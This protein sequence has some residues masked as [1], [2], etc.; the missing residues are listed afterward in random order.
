MRKGQV[1]FTVILGIIIIAVIAIFYAFSSGLIGPSVI[2]PAV[3]KQMGVVK[4]TV[5]NFIRAAVADIMMN[6][7]MYG[8]YLNDNS[9]SNPVK[10]LGHNV[11]YWQYNGQKTIPDV[12]ANLLEGIENYL[13][14]HKASLESSFSGKDVAIGDPHVALDLRG[15]QL[16]VTVNMPT[17]VMN[18]QIREP[19]VVNIPTM[20]GDIYDFSNGFVSLASSNRYFEYFTLSSML[21]S[22]IESGS[23]A[24]PV[25]VYLLECGD[26][27]FKTWWDVKPEMEKT[28]ESTLAHTYMQ[29]KVP[30]NIMYNSSYPKYALPDVNGKTYPDLDITFH[31]PDSFELTQSNFQF[32]PNPIIA[33]AEPVPF[34]STCIS[35]PL[36][37]YYSLNY[38]VIVRVKDP[39]TNNIFTFAYHVYIYNNKPGDWTQ[40]IGGYTPEDQELICSTPGCPIKVAVKD[41]DGNPVPYAAVGYSDCLLGRTEENGV[42]STTGP[43]GIAPLNVYKEGYEIYDEPMSSDDL[44]N[45]TITLRKYPVMNI[46]LYEV[47]IANNAVTS[48]YWISA[49]DVKPLDADTE[50]DESALITF[51]RVPEGDAY[52]RFYETGMGTERFIPPGYYSISGTLM[53]STL[54]TRYGGFAIQGYPVSEEVTDLYIYLPY[55]YEFQG[56]T[57]NST[58]VEQVGIFTSVLGKCGIGP[59]SQEPYDTSNLPC[60]K[61][62]SDVIA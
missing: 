50:R 11:P 44:E 13:Q 7:S 18:Y 6:M 56:L 42:L 55:N 41:T 38:P 20:F 23:H 58:I 33:M 43:C 29:D 16:T 8:G 25:F 27:V 17:T 2:P 51:Y 37:V 49:G 1:E 24:V 62:Y 60:I 36:V 3:E 39:L 52:N 10:F 57:D 31:L 15:N 21:I 40:G 19:Y 30:L 35:D 12:Q 14:N 34:V 4:S 45:A 47:N 48:E 26:S 61:A 59:V 46:H 9:F 5:N 53:S 22:P 28:I 32:T 54:E